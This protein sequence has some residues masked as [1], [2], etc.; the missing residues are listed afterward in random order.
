M[1]GFGNDLNMLEMKILSVKCGFGPATHI[2]E[3]MG[4]LEAVSFFLKCDAWGYFNEN[5]IE[6]KFKEE[7][8]SNIVF[9]NDFKK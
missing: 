2:D 7:V 6:F 3:A 4:Y 5:K 9:L 8:K 1:D